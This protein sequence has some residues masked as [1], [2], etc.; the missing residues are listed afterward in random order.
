MSVMGSRIVVITESSKHRI[1][2]RTARVAQQPAS[3]AFRPTQ[4]LSPSFLSFTPSVQR[5]LRPLRRRQCRPKSRSSRSRR[6]SRRRRTSPR[7]CVSREVAVAVET[8]FDLCLASCPS[9]L[10]V[11]RFWDALSFWRRIRVVRV[12]RTLPFFFATA[13]LRRSSSSW[14]HIR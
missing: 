12:T 13:E 9:S 5:L 1:G 14:H 7:R 3:L 10:F 6:R 2:A 11:F 4:R 8:P